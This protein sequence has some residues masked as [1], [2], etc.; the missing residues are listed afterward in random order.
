MQGALEFTAPIW[1]KISAGA[2]D[3]IAKL[4]DR[5]ADMRLTAEEAFNH[6]WI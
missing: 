1:E 4:L 2:K 3:I 5:Q 6:P